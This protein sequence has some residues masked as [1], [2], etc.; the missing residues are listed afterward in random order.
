[1]GGKDRDRTTGA[2]DD[3]LVD[4]IAILG[5]MGECHD[6]IREYGEM[7]ITTHIISC[8]SPKDAQTT[9]DAFYAKNFSF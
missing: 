6:R 4:D 8:V 5:S 1:M 2:L 9:Y 7:G 3:K